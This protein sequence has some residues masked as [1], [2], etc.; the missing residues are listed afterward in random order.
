MSFLSDNERTLRLEHNANIADIPSE[1]KS[2][3]LPGNFLIIRRQYYID[4]TKTES[5]VLRPL[6]KV[7]SG[8]DDR[9]KVRFSDKTFAPVGVVL[10]VGEGADAQKYKVG[11][12]VLLDYR[13]LDRGSYT[14]PLNLDEPVADGTGIERVPCHENGGLVIYIRNTVDGRENN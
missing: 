1:L 13:L 12:E 6:M 9:A 14:F 5:G 8:A 3:I 10:K 2:G 11:D 4:M 7:E